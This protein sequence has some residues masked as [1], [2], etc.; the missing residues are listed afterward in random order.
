MGQTLNMCQYVKYLPETLIFEKP[1]I[2]ETW[3]L[4]HLIWHASN[5]KYAQLKPFQYS[6][7]H[8]KSTKCIIFA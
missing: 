7:S 6:F 2:V 3:N 4:C 1:L 8:S 5:P